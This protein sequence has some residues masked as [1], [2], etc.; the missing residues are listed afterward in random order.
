MVIYFIQ[1]LIIQS[2]TRKNIH[3]QVIANK[4]IFPKYYW[5][6]D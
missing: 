3:A 2:I 1:Q 4:R 6:S 5:K